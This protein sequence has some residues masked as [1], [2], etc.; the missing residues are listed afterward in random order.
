MTL[1]EKVVNC[2]VLDLVILYN[3]G[4]KFD[5][6]QDH[7]K[8]LLIFFCVEPFVGADHVITRL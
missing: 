6:I 8:K 3:F 2:K 1:N 5:I 7:M 4:I